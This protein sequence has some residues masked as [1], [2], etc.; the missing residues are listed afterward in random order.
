MFKWV[1]ILTEP[2][3]A[4]VARENFLPRFSLLSFLSMELG[5]KGSASQHYTNGLMVTAGVYESISDKAQHRDNSQNAQKS[6]SMIIH[7][8]DDAY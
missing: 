4:N 8:N 2:N 3:Q 6:M 7:V 1:R 5:D